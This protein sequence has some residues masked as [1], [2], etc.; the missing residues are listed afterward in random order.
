M[1]KP[2]QEPKQD[3]SPQVLTDLR[4]RTFQPRSNRVEV[5]DLGTENQLYLLVQPSGHKSF[6]F[7][8]ERGGK[9]QKL[10]LG[11][12][13]EDK[14]GL[15]LARARVM[16]EEAK[17]K[18]DAGHDPAG[19]KQEAKRE[20]HAAKANTLQA[21]CEQFLKRKAG[22]KIDSK[23]GSVSF[24]PKAKM[25]SGRSVYAIL[26]RLVFPSP[27]AKLPISDIKRKTHITALLD[28]IEDKNGV[29]MAQS[30][31]AI[32]RATMNWWASRDE[33]FVSPIVRG[34]ART[35]VKER[36]RS[37][38]LSDDEI[39]DLW[40][41]LDTAD[42]P[43]CYASFVRLL[44]YTGLRRC[45]ASN[46]TA[47]E[48]KFENGRGYVLTIP[49][50]RYKSKHDHTVALTKQ[51]MAL[52]ED[53]T[54]PFI[55]STT[56]G[57]KAFVGFSAAKRALD[58]EIAR[59]RK[60]DGRPPMEPWVTHDIRRSVRSLLSKLKIDADIAERTIGHA[61]PGV[62]AT[63]DRYDYFDEKRDALMRLAALVDSI[64]NPPPPGKVIPFQ[65]AAGGKD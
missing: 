39:R 64:V 11:T 60:R 32:L 26:E 25:R 24:D 30:V 62:R 46:M 7:R 37:R 49:A 41:A 5:R 12:W 36:A 17:D 28:K 53:G 20:R 10:T 6:A 47:A 63:Y 8:Y 54:A 57:L 1:A 18:V 56:G 45:E 13:R 31:L 42:V 19:Q 3:Y 38:I 61:I 21:V 2:K 4:I 40:A 15:S 35:T 58:A 27:I 9:S 48:I 23:T 44:F 29:A 50:T 43:E 51:A 55:F 16:A 22:L 52:I 59:I 34:M 14:K 65:Q 33:E